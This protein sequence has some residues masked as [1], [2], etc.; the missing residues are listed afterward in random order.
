MVE[1]EEADSSV[2]ISK[3]RDSVLYKH[4]VWTCHLLT[5]E[6]FDIADAQMEAR[7]AQNAI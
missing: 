7:E 4:K 5:E 2:E 6:K 3:G 1:N